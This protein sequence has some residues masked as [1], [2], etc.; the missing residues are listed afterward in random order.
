MCWLAGVGG[1]PPGRPHA[2]LSPLYVISWF[3]HFR[4]RATPEADRRASMTLRRIDIRQHRP[5]H[6]K[7]SS[8]NQIVALR[9]TAPPERFA[10]HG[11]FR[12]Y[13][14]SEEEARVAQDYRTEG[15]S[16]VAKSEPET[17]YLP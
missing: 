3:R 12:R 13:R 9:L 2:G 5:V 11:T 4:A 1:C 10:D 6:P 8:R 17:D 7:L 14:V 15:A 16:S